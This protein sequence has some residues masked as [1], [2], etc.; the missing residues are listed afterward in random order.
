MA[1]I[2]IFKILQSEQIAFNK[3]DNNF[4]IYSTFLKNKNNNAENDIRDNNKKKMKNNYNIN[5]NK[6]KS[7]KINNF[8]NSIIF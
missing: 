6:L 4:D 7:Q 1:M 3:E 5:K 2:K 8:I